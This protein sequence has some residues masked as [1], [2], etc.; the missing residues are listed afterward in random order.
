MVSNHFLKC[1]GS[2][3]SVGWKDV[4]AAVICFMVLY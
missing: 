3:N 1:I 2:L 4:E